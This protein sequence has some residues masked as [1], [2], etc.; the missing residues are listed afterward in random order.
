MIELQIRTDRRRFQEV[1]GHRPE[2]RLLIEAATE[3]EWIAGCLEELGHE[4][5]VADPNYAPMYAHRSRR[6]KTDR[7]DA[8]ALAEACRLGT[9]R[10][11]HR[12]SSIQRDRRTGLG[13]RELLIRTRS[14][15]ILHVRSLL[16]RE[17]LRL[18]PGRAP[19]IPAAHTHAVRGPASPARRVSGAART[20]PR[21]PR[22][23][24]G[25]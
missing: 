19:Q 25:C 23:A 24:Q 3:S 15:W 16:R 2:A 9:Y 8:H 14:R 11:A 12:T 7:R 10:P 21:D 22:R 18:P 6:I 17:G 5:I 4:V 20:G 1:F 13:V